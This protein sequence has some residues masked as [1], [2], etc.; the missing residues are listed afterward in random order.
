VSLGRLVLAAGG[1]VWRGHHGDIEV[2]VI[3]RPRYD[4]WTLPKGKLEPGEPELVAAVREVGEEIGARVAV[5]R[6][7]RRQVHP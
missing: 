4:D 7:A 6:R 1:V 5:S 2:A 3:H